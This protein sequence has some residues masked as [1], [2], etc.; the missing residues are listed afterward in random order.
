MS[1]AQER[2]EQAT[3]KR[4]KEA[5]S[6]GR[7]AKSTDL[8][9]WV[10]VGAAAVMLP[11]TLQTGSNAA[12]GQLFT[13][14]SVIES[15]DPAKA[16]A[17]LGDGLGS[18]MATIG[19]LLGV[20]AL[21]V[22]G[23]AAVQGGIHFKK[24]EGKYEQ[25]NVVKGLGR[26]FG[27]R[28]L[29]EG[30]KTLLKSAVVGIGLFLVVQGLMPVLLT[31]GSMP[32]TSLLS[33][34]S[35]GT[36]GLLQAAIGAGLVLAGLDVLVVMRRNRKHTRMSKQEIRDEN[37][38]SEGDP[39][40]RSHRRS[41][42]LAMSRNRM[43]AAIGGADVVLVNPTHIA[44][45]VKYEPGKSAPRV[46]AKGAGAIALRIREKAEAERVPIV[47]DI[48]LARALH[49]GCEIGE[50]IP[51]E[52]YNSVARVLA[53]VMSLKQRGSAAGFHTMRPQLQGGLS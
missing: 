31:S 39:L 16:L 25:F 51:V 21:A 34:A 30:A 14:R 22:V 29:W 2:T 8:T 6:K 28:A 36:A 19:P 24:L 18:I 32:L 52:L 11:F 9:A 44:V 17:A 1:D 10:G 46:V 42:Q 4:M 15:P 45:A 37:K 7:L 40:V 5:R 53:F 12:V 48:P 3:E 49:A 26:V 23:A 20:G 47:K 43:I 50:E 13:V 35:G 38:N 27:M 41:R 33:A